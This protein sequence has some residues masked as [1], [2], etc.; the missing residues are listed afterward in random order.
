M[1]KLPDLIC[2][3]CGYN[4]RG[5]EGPIC[6]ECGEFPFDARSEIWTIEDAGSVTD[7]IP[8][9]FV[10]PGATAAVGI[11]ALTVFVIRSLIDGDM[12]WQAL[13]VLCVLV[14]ASGG[15]LL[16]WRARRSRLP[17]RRPFVT[18]LAR[19]LLVGNRGQVKYGV[20][21]CDFRRVYAADS[22]YWIEHASGQA[23]RLPPICLDHRC[24]QAIHHWL[25]AAREKYGAADAQ[26]T[27]QPKID[28]NPD[29]TSATES[30]GGDT[31]A[32][33]ELETP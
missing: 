18:T 19:G 7:Q 28:T 3:L 5:L 22:S 33:G 6:P 32:P 24:A 29:W 17:H 23:L 11:F 20:A 1:P 14:V 10:I 25:I 15:L 8:A 26:S 13:A 16:A 2:P 31:A 12:N 30:M 4:L 21:W 27:E 9:H